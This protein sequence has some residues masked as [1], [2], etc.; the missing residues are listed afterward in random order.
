MKSLVS[1]AFVLALLVLPA[2]GGKKQTTQETVVQPKIEQCNEVKS[3]EMS[4]T[5]AERT[6][7]VIPANVVLSEEDLK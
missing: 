4:T 5:T 3:L 2:C 6:S 1:G 7:G